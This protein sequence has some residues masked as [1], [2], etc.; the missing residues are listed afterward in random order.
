MR[1]AIDAYAFSL[2]HSLNESSLKRPAQLIIAGEEAWHWGGAD[3][4]FWN[5]ANTGAKDFNALFFD[6]HA[7]VS[8]QAYITP[9]GVPSYDFNWVFIGHNWQYEWDIYDV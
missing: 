8:K 2:Q 6:G 1:H 7:K 3:P 9:I 4:Y 5:P